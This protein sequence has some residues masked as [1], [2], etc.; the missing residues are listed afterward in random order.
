MEQW[1]VLEEDF[2]QLYLEDTVTV[3]VIYDII[4]NTR[5]TKLSKL[6]CGYGYRIQKSAFECILSKEKCDKMLREIETF[7]QKDDLIR[8]YRLNQMV[9]TTVYGERQE[10]E[11]EL[12]Y[13][14]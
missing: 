2:E 3:V 14:V 12:Y 9:Q 10:A 4:S 13:F 5:R 6:L 8:I 11:N 7:A 1:D